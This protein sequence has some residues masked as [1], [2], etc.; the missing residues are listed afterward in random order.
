[1]N[2]FDRNNPTFQK[3]NYHNIT[4]KGCRFF[5]ALCLFAMLFLV[6]SPKTIRYTVSNEILL[7]S[8]ILKS[9]FTKEKGERKEKDRAEDM[10]VYFPNS[11]KTR[12]QPWFK[13]RARFSDRASR[14]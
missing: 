3:I 2:T 4:S 11:C 7:K 8:F 1:M 13:G 5:H 9:L 12:S 14:S 10:L 6:F